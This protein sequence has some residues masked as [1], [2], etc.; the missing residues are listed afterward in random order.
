LPGIRLPRRV[1]GRVPE[2]AVQEL[3][4]RLATRMPSPLDELVLTD[5]RSVLLSTTRGPDG[6][7]RLRLHRAF[8]GA[9]DEALTAVVD[10]AAGARGKKRQEAL[11][12]LR[13]HVDTWRCV[14]RRRGAELLPRALLRPR[15][16]F[17]D[18]LAIREELNRKLFRGKLAPA[19]TW[20]RWANLGRRRSTIRLGSYDE[21]QALIRIHPALDQDWV[22]RHFVAAVVHHEMLH[23]HLPSRE[24][25]GRRCL[26]GEEFRRQERELPGFRAAEAWLAANLHRLLRS[27]P[28]Q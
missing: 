27:R 14:Q 18:L 8:V 13:E 17:H 10:F 20:G 12:R 21:G 24:G 15:G 5:N 9:S 19:I 28:R 25:G 16:E 26:H 7:L 6:R 2:A 11:S 23:A 3:A 4:F 22:P 1:E